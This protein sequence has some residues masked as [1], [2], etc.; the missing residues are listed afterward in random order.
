MS[1]KIAQQSS[2]RPHDIPVSTN[3]SKINLWKQEQADLFIHNFDYSELTKINQRIEDCSQKTDLS[4]SDIDL[5]VQDIENLF[6]NT[7][8][9]TFGTQKNRQTNQKK[10]R[11]PWFN[12]ECRTARNTYHKVRRLYNKYKNDHYKNMLRSVSKEYKCVISRNVRRKK[13]ETIQK[14]RYIK[15]RDPKEYWR[16][17][18]Q[19]VERNKN[20]V[21]VDTFFNFFQRVNNPD[22]RESETFNSNDTGPINDEINGPITESEIRQAVHSLKRNKSPGIDQILNE[23]IISSLNLMLPLYVKLFNLVFDTALIPENWLI[24]EIL[25]IYKNKGDINNPENYRPITLLSC[26]G[27]LFTA[28][29]NTRLTKYS[30]RYNVITDS[31]TG[32]RKG[33]STSDNL[34]VINSLIEI[35]K[36]KSRKLYCALIDFKQAF[37]TVWREGLWQKLISYNINGKCLKLIQCLY[38]NIKSRIKSPGGTSAFFPCRTGVRQG[39]NLSPFLFSIFINDLETYFQQHNISGINC[40]YNDDDIYIYF[41]LFILLY[42]DDTVIFS[43]T[44]EELQ[45]ALNV[46]G[47]YCDQWKLIVNASKTKVLTI[48]RGRPTTRE[49]F[50]FKQTELEIVREYKYLGIFL[51]RSGSF[52]TTKKYIAEQA[53]KALFSLFKKIRTLD[54]SFDLQIDL[55]NKTIKPI[56]LYG[57]EIW[58]YGNCDIIERVQLKFL[59]FAFNLKKSTPTFMIYGELGIMPISIDIKSKIINFWAK[60]SSTS[61]QPTR[62]SFLMYS[63]LYNMHKNNICKS[64]YIE[65]VKSILDSCGFSG[66]W[67]SQNV[68]NPKWLSLAILQRLKDQYLQ[69]WFSIVDKSSSAINYRLFKDSYGFSKYLNLLSNKNCKILM[70]FRT[71][72]TKFPVEV[73]RWH[74]IPLNERICTFC[75]KDVGDEYHYLLIC[76]YFRVARS[77][78]LNRYYYRNPNTLKFKNLINTEDKNLLKKLCCFISVINDAF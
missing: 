41:K 53:N 6:Q 61:E 32:F 70:R 74:S 17:L 73:G 35:L 55:F 47:Q 14:L 27:K 9:E 62:L 56:L 37:D 45:Q 26:L 5:I 33:F 67:Q 40:E 31:Q 38:G 20:H 22:I 75:N 10:A 4:K 12:S 60:I 49:R 54:L 29:I 72:N 23:H 63:V 57:A 71:R 43:E 76:D 25:P 77:N 52:I 50:Y 8:K 7:C 65:N 51:S 42:A 19:G 24:G 16:I 1:I 48:S 36:S 59:K 39:E 58:G 68:I 44:A 66:I 28:I 46:F 69:N 78:F 13:D 11:K 2:S 3:Y 21:N 34:F 30:D 15:S 64:Q 18:N